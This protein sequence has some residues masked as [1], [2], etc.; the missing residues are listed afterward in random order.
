[1]TDSILRQIDN[2][3]SDL[4]PRP[5]P[6]IY[7]SPI[8]SKN[9]SDSP[10]KSFDK[11]N[12]ID[13]Y[14]TISFNSFKQDF[15]IS[16]KFDEIPELASIENLTEN[17]A[18]EEKFKLLMEQNMRLITIINETTEEKEIWKQKY[19]NLAK[20]AERKINDFNDSL[21]VKI[22]E[23]DIYRSRDEELFKLQLSLRDIKEYFSKKINEILH[24][25]SEFQHYNE[26]LLKNIKKLETEKFTINAETDRLMENLIYKGQ[27]IDRFEE[28]LA[29]TKLSIKELNEV[30]D[31]LSGRK[32]RSNSLDREK[33]N[34]NIKVIQ[35]EM[36]ELINSN[37]EL[38]SELERFITVNE[39]K[40]RQ[41]QLLQEKLTENNKNDEL[42]R[43]SQKLLKKSMKFKYN[44]ENLVLKS[45]ENENLKKKLQEKEKELNS[46]KFKYQ[47]LFKE[48]NQRIQSLSSHYE[49]S[50]NSFESELEK[51]Y[52][53]EKSKLMT[54]LMDERTEN[55]SIIARLEQKLKNS[56][57]ELNQ[58]K[59]NI[60]VELEDLSGKYTQ[61]Q[62]KYKEKENQMINE[63]N[64]L[65]VII[66][67]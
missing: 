15:D 6:K 3:P 27:I 56:E 36:K 60:N 59:E 57:K 7:S 66:N 49:Q 43:I 2:F 8:P 22:T 45:N 32:K 33:S 65:N 50:Q 62:E 17:E 1:M 14:K 28:E 34:K 51:T 55:H 5:P 31:D 47:I 35:K 29:Q 53:E 18:Y 63:I 38:K 26:E 20:V 42:L 67:N 54:C 11:E 9:F 23:N 41:I 12:V 30:F 48:S 46:L 19:E 40:E 4:Y 64:R 37:N 16:K 58:F 25:K 61:Q 21:Q 52:E 44:K 10:N 24:E 39:E 13:T